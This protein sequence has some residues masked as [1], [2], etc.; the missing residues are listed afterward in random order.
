M[1][2]WN[3][4]NQWE[5]KPTKLS[6]P[7]G[8]CGPHLIHPSLNWPH[9]PTQMTARVVHAL[10]HNYATYPVVPT[11]YKDAPNSPKTALPLWRSSPHLIQPSL[12]WPNSSFQM[13]FGSNQPFCHRT[14]SRLTVSVCMSILLPRC[15][16]TLL[17]YVSIELKEL[18]T[19]LLT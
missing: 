13:A 6:L 16:V 14:H 9:S 2:S 4:W 17:C 7:L 11:G 12:N 8:A 15:I 10:P 19:Y 1:I 5:L 18:L 3:H